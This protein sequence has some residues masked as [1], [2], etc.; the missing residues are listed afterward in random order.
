[1]KREWMGWRVALRSL[2]PM[3]L[4]AAAM[5]LV[6][7]SASAAEDAEESDKPAAKAGAEKKGDADKAAPALADL[8]PVYSARLR[9][10]YDYRKSGD[11]KDNDFY[12]YATAEARN[13]A[14][15]RADFYTSLRLKSDLDSKDSSASLADDPFRSV[16]ESNGVTEN[17][18][19]QLYVD[20][21]DRDRNLAF[22][23]GR[24]YVE[25]ADYLHIDGGQLIAK[26]SGDLGGRIYAGR[27]VSYYDSDVSDDLAAGV[28]VIGRPW[29]GNKTR[30]TLARYHDDSADEDDQDYYL[31]V[32]QELSE[33]SRVRGQLSILNDEFRMGRGDWYFYSP[34]GETDLSLGGSYWGSFDAKT[35]AFSPLYSVL[36]EQDPYTLLYARLNQQI[37]PKWTVSPGV[38]LRFADAGE[39]GYSNR[40]YENYD[41]TLSYEPSRAFSSSVALEYWNVEESDS[42]LGVSGE[43]RYRRNR[44]WE[45]SGGV[46]FAEYTYDTYSDISY[47]TSGGQTTISETGTIIEE[48]PFVK[49]YFVR[50]KWRVNKQIT[51]RAQFDVEDDDTQDDLALRARGSVEVRL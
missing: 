2:P 31:D 34:D 10:Q 29:T 36:G 25:I 41:I 11:E 4:L 50:S 19:R 30:L 43:L 20:V 15:G 16:D 14:N 49:T 46:L 6:N 7:L 51:L 9:L 42:F 27:P 24:Q 28:S 26:E 3:A 8:K 5:A 44:V 13:L 37:V 38:S 32:R 47:A 33:S 21:H 1:M 18:I 48:T 23:A 35:R 40:D 12:A 39:N 45:I 22:R 17:R